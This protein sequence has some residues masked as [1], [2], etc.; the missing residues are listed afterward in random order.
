MLASQGSAGIAP[1]LCACN[2]RGHE[3]EVAGNTG[4]T[5]PAVGLQNVQKPADFVQI[6]TSEAVQT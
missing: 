5:R 4:S 1:Q 3:S 6:F 2:Y